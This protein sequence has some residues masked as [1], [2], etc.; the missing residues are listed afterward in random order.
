MSLRERSVCMREAHSLAIDILAIPYFNHHHH[1]SHL[2]VHHQCPHTLPYPLHIS[3]TIKHACDAVSPITPLYIP[4]KR[5]Q[6]QSF[7][8][9]PH[10][11][12]DMATI[13]LQYDVFRQEWKSI[14]HQGEWGG[15][16]GL[17]PQP[18][19][20]IEQI[21]VS[22]RRNGV[23]LKLRSASRPHRCEHNLRIATEPLRG[24]LE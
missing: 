13:K 15:I 9:L 5:N 8:L 3:I 6:Q 1:I 2:R 22:E 23:K 24:E 17:I 14:L 10:S 16:S 18:I 4:R 21:R 11:S 7:F 19:W 20:G 12:S